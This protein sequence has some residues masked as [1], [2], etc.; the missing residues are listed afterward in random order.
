MADGSFIEDYETFDTI[1]QYQEQY[2]ER[3]DMQLRLY[4]TEKLGFSQIFFDT[5]DIK[6]FFIMICSIKQYRE[7]D[8]FKEFLYY[9]Q[10]N[11][12][13]IFPQI[14][15]LDEKQHEFSDN[16]LLNLYTKFPCYTGIYINEIGVEKI[17]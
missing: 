4:Q 17:I 3:F 10:S 6:M 13:S 2:L 12:S 1:K 15:E 8:L 5:Y 11:I 7:S 9:A 16:I 14:K